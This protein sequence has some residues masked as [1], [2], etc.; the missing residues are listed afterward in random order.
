MGN[1]REFQGA[2]AIFIDAN[3]FLHHAFDGRP[4]AADFL[5]RVESKGLRAYTSTLVLE[6]VMYILLIQAAGKADR[7]GKAGEDRK[8]AIRSVRRYFEYLGVLKA[9]GLRVLDLTDADVSAALDIVSEAGLAS[10]DACHAAVMRRKGISHIATAD[11]DFRRL[12][13]VAVWTP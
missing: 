5:A 3:V 12:A 9:C 1:L 7:D 10:A 6:E 13:G 8:S 4:G 11:G 2:E